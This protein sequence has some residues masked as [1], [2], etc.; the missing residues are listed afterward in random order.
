MRGG[1]RGFSEEGIVS[2]AISD[3]IEILASIENLLRVR[4]EYR[5]DM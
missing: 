1:R 5:W 2:D 3:H 4:L